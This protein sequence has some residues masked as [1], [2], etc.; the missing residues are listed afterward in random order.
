MKPEQNEDTQNF[1]LFFIV[2][3]L[4]IMVGGIID[5]K[6][7]APEDWFTLHVLF[8]IGFILLCLGSAVYLGLGWYAAKRS[9][10]HIQ[11]ALNDR[12][13]ERDLWRKRAKDLLEGLGRAIDA[14]MQT[15]GL[16]QV[17]K[18]TALFLLKGYSHK[19]IAHLCEKSERTVRQHAVAVYRK[20]G[21]SG[22]AELAAF[23]LE[24]LLVPMDEQ[25]SA[26][27]GEPNNDAPVDEAPD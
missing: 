11:R 20:S 21:L 26:S 25:P 12:Q 13:S 23:F 7:D 24:D 10:G 4:T 18:E 27:A 2:L 9:L 8:E 6:F 16:T 1:S 14:Q 3:L 17:E 19:E 5:L 22:R 15:W